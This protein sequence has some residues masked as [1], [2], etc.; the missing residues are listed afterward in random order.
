LSSVISAPRVYAVDK[1]TAEICTDMQVAGF[2][3]DVQRGRELADVLRTAEA[4]ARASAEAAVN[5]ALKPTK[6]GGFSTKDLHAAFFGD[7]GAP[8]FFR[9]SITGRPSLGID[10]MRGYAAAHDPRLRKLALAILDWRR[11]RKVRSTYI[12]GAPVNPDT[13]RVHPTWLNYGTVSGRMSCQKP[14]LMNLPRPEN[15]P[16]REA[17]GVRGLYIAKPG[18]RLVGFDKKQLEM[19]IAAYASGDEVMIQA[20]ESKDLH[21]WNA[22]AIFAEKFLN[23]D[24]ATRKALRTLAKSSAFAV[25]YM[26]EASTVYARLVAA[27]EPVRLQQVEAMLRR[28]RSAF[29]TYYRW[30][31]AAL[32][33]IVRT[34]WVF[35]PIVGRG[36][37]L[38]HEPAPTEAANF[39]IQ[40]GAAD[41]MNWQLPD[42]VDDLHT[43]S[44]RSRLV[45]QVHDAGYFEVPVSDVE[46]VVE[47]MHAVLETPVVIASSGKRLEAVFPIDVEVSERWH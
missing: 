34:G 24:P 45:A 9:S 14:N 30:Q 8:I 40:S 32:L 44:P 22:E 16:T 25:C 29:A 17:G 38:G 2:A 5:R 46:L 7:L 1:R 27:G 4:A 37:W 3:F 43:R 12:D 42:L 26:A 11:A 10:S 23:A 13:G 6:S 35:S 18:F 31:A 39:P 15:D 19:R 33:D 28:M 41:V 47:R 21:T 20:C 36:R